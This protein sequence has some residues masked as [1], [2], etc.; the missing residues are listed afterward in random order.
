MNNFIKNKKGISVLITVII[1]SAVTLTVALSTTLIGIDETQ[2]GLY[3]HKALET[4]TA[5][6]G[7]A[8]EAL[9][10]LHNDNFYNGENLLIGDVSCTITVNGAGDNRTINV[11][12]VHDAIYAREIE[13]EVNLAGT[14]SVTSWQE[15]T[16]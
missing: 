11:V 12:S 5:S 16:N 9:I 8:E 4:F 3:Q 13:L 7:C 6:D 1:I 15:I 10:K 14:F 2:I